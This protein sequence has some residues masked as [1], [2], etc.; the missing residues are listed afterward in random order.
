MVGLIIIR[1]ARETKAAEWRDA[2]AIWKTVG[3]DRF[4]CSRLPT[5]TSSLTSIQSSSN[6]AG[7]RG[8]AVAAD[9][10]IRKY[11]DI[12]SGVD[13][14]PFAIE[15]SGV[16]CGESMIWNLSPKSAVA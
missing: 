3:A 4:R 16:A 8:A 2:V 10:K 12:V 6:R 1:C 14:S 15:T 5:F 7:S 9:E 13:F 11:F